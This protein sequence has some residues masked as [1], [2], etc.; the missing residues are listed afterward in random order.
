MC[1][2]NRGVRLIRVSAI[3]ISTVILLCQEILSKIRTF[4]RWERKLISFLKVEGLLP[5]KSIL[6]G[7]E[8]PACFKFVRIVLTTHFSIKIEYLKRRV[9]CF[10]CRYTRFIKEQVKLDLYSYLS[11]KVSET[12]RYS[13]VNLIVKQTV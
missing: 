1:P 3:R 7:D 6:H 12:F 8:N 9:K 4:E 13:L 5:L 11:Q 10:V 2:P